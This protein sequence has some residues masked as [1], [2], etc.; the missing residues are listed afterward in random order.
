MKKNIPFCI[1]LFLSFAFTNANAYDLTVAKDGSGDY[2]TVQAAINASPNGLTSP[3]FIYIKNGTYNEVI[4][5]PSNKTFIYL[6]GQSVANTI[7][8]YNNGA[9][10]SN[11][12]GGTLGT[13]GSG[14]I[15]INANNFTAENITFQNTFGDGSQAVAVIIN[16]D[17]AAFKNCRFMGNQDTLYTKGSGNPRAYF[18][19]CYIDGNIDFIF[20]NAIALFDS[21]TVYAKTRT[22]AGSSFMTAASTP[23]G[24]AYGYVFRNCIFPA[25]TGGTQ[26]YLGRPWENETGEV[27]L[28][29]NKVV[30]LNGKFGGGLII[31]AG[32]T[33]WDAGTDTSLIYDGEYQSE[34][35]DG[36]LEDVSQRVTWS[37]Q[38]SPTDAANYTTANILGSWNPCAIT[39]TFCNDSARDIAVSNF[40][41]TK[42]AAVSTL[43]WNISWAM[44]GIQYQLY[45]SS[46][47]TTFS[48]IGEVDAVNDTS[49]NF[50]LTDAVPPAGSVY[51]YYV[52]ASLPGTNPDTT[53]VVSISSAPTI[54][55]TGT[56][57]SFAQA[58]GTPSA[59]QT[60]I[61]TG[62]NLVDNVTITPPIGFEVSSDG[63][64]WYDAYNSDPPLVLTPVN[65]SISDTISVRLNAIL[66]LTYSGNIT[67]T[68]TGTGANSV[69][70]PVSGTT[71]YQLNV[72]NILQQWPLDINN[73][74]SAGVR[75][76]S[77]I[78]STSSFN[79]LYT[80]NGTTVPAAP[81][82]SAAFGQ[83]FGASANGD[84]TWSTAVGGPGGTLNRTFYEQ[85]TVTDQSGS[86]VL[87][88]DS[89]LFNT[90]FYNT[91][92]GTKLAIAYS[93]SGF[94]SDSTDL[95]TA[96]F[97]TPIA[98]N[99]TTSST[100]D[101]YALA[102][103]GA[104]GLVI[105]QDTF[106]FR[107]YYAVSS[108]SAGRYALLKNVIVKGDDGPVI[109]PVTL[110]SFN[111]LPNNNS[112][113]V[114]WQTTNEINSKNFT[115]ERS[116]NG[117]D[118]TAIGT[119][120]ANDNTGVNNYS[121]NDN[122][123][124]V[125]TSYYRLLI[126]DKDGHY[127]T[128]QV[129]AINRSTAGLV[130]VY[131]DPAKDFINI[132]Y[133]VLLQTCVAKLTSAEGKLLGNISLPKG[134]SETVANISNLS[135]GVYFISINDGNNEKTLMF[136]K[137]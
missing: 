30:Y 7:L 2:T 67:N 99:K 47:D 31:P 64:T 55:V 112:V 58:I 24:Q 87:R 76:P 92:S 27:P 46:N 94:T 130:S 84:G 90:D 81:A 70:I 113:E 103:N 125:G 17:M 53:S 89:L 86:G 51:Y 82:Y 98:V 49:V 54:T 12:S 129:D 116:S 61:L 18:K 120:T 135:A 15:T 43:N 132:E 105:D 26:Y 38:L 91:N 73:T 40:R 20:G 93:Q 102:F 6:V 48:K 1:A 119:V 19:N 39:A 28:A 66:L 104:D 75:F 80:S 52:V 136:V 11:G 45:R 131:P 4:T 118:F 33:I 100:V 108:S 121:F 133:P 5:I 63:V 8:T 127:K 110:V 107:L 88:I 9:S 25:N 29:N 13:S 68:T 41:G 117:T 22:T 34:N 60:Y 134:S 77:I 16:A 106:T 62:V 79:K 78:A 74:D 57:G 97:I 128:S 23:A 123:P 10:T 32:W 59:V 122:D 14:S 124:L 101:T 96:S 44:N 3:Y 42:G 114:K 126:N 69:N 72:S 111:A 85:F 65:G 95:P 71:S 35:M 83:A 37:Y 115:I 21:C 137:Q 56:L 36:T 109:V 50:Q